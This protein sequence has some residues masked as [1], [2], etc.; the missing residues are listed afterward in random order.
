MMTTDTEITVTAV[1]RGIDPWSA[2]SEAAA[3]KGEDRIAATGQSMSGGERRLATEATKGAESGSERDTG[4][5]KTAGHHLQKGPIKKSIRDLEG[6][7][8]YQLLLNLLH[9]HRSH[10]GRLLKIQTLGRHPQ[11][12]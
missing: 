1:V 2:G 7:T 3:P 12:L 4:T 10:L 11:R 6:V 5:G 9:V 8:V